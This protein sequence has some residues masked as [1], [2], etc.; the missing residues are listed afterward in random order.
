[1]VGNSTTVL[2]TLPVD[3]AALVSTFC[4]LYLGVMCLLALTLVAEMF[5]HSL[6]VFVSAV[7]SDAQH[8]LHSIFRRTCGHPIRPESRVGYGVGAGQRSNCFDSSRRFHRELHERFHGTVQIMG[9]GPPRT[10]RCAK[11]CPL[12]L[13]R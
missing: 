12:L 6:T 2:A 9:S 8:R 11:H 10:S 7:G 4:V 5:V 3:V 13:L 1:M